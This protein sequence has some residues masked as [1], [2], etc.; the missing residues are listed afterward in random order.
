MKKLIALVGLFV[1]VTFGSIFAEKVKITTGG[2]DFGLLNPVPSN[3]SQIVNAAP[4]LKWQNSDVPVIDSVM[5]DTTSMIAAHGSYSWAYTL[6]VMDTTSQDSTVTFR[7]FGQ[8]GG[9]KDT[10]VT[11]AKTLQTTIVDFLPFMDVTFYHFDS[12]AVGN[13][14][15]VAYMTTDWQ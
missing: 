5:A 12:C 8:G 1:L 14:F 11:L 9:Y 15:W 4:S 13:V 7:R 2:I 3:V 10:T 6:V